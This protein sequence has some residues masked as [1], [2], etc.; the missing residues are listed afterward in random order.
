LGCFALCWP[1]ISS[2]GRWQLSLRRAE[3]GN[4]PENG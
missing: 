2:T 3:I 4:F 1:S